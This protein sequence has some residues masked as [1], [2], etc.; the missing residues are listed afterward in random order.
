MNILTKNQKRFD[1]ISFV[2]LFGVL[3]LLSFNLTFND[4]KRT[5]PG[6]F[7]ADKSEYYAYLPATFIYGWDVKKFPH[8]IDTVYQG[9]I[10]DYKKDKLIIKMTCGVAILATPFF[11]ITH[12]I[13]LVSGLPANG[14]SDFYE[15]MGLIT[16]V[17]YL[18]LGLF[19]LKRF[20]DR[21]FKHYISWLSLLF[22]LAG[23]N[24]YHYGL[25][26]GWMSHVFSFFLFSLYLFL[27]KG[28]LDGGKSS[29]KR[30]LLISLVVSLAV[31]IRPTSILLLFWL[32][33]LDVRSFREIWE[34]LLFFFH[35]RYVVPFAFIGILVFIPQFIYWHYLSGS[36]L[37]YSYQTETF[38]FWKCPMIIPVWFAPL[39]GLFIYNPLVVFMVAGII[40]MAWQRILNA[41]FLSFF[42]LL[43]SYMIGSWHI[44]YFGGSFGCR[45]FVEF[46]ALF[47]LAF[48]Y[49]LVAILK[50][51]NLFIR[52][53]IIFL[54]LLCTIYTQQ[55]IYHSRW[56][57]SSYWAWD[58]FRDYL[59]S[60][61]ILHFRKN[62]YTYIN[63]FGNISFDPS[64]NDTRINVHSPT[65]ACLLSPEYEIACDYVHGLGRFLDKRVEKITASCWVD[66]F[67]FD[68][69]DAY[70][71]CSI[72]HQ[73][74]GIVLSRTIPFNSFGTKRGH[75]TKIFTEIPVPFWVNNPEYSF[76]FY[77]RNVH[78][79]HILLDD[80]KI[81][82]K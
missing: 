32:V 35:P 70:M 74:A 11:L 26:E 27:L 55:M 43:I 33:L 24:L 12:G 48:A 23:T 17:F 78:K 34:R 13:A 16:P 4:G 61:N 49:L 5:N 82:F 40:L 72:E 42:F 10:L 65:K 41:W 64:V 67:V 62:S 53:S 38:L 45:P 14:F 54:M 77:I 30:F 51:R 31:L 18:V 68:N 80:I 76:R 63:D 66:P 29:Y 2:F 25:V 59:D 60:K 1:L 58:D 36:F 73:K 19:F 44:W 22:I 3:M 50:I 28:F 56:N 9:F 71:V 21:Y 20:L 46:Y 69:C 8:R 79:R 52:C 39:N 75:W 81:T 37:Y 15:K 57:T 7:W 47:S 6:V